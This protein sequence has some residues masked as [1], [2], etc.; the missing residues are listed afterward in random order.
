MAFTDRHE[1]Y[2]LLCK[3]MFRLDFK[4]YR[5]EHTTFYEYEGDNTLRTKLIVTDVDGMTI[6][7][8]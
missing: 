5:V 7:G 8:N 3:S 2:K 1:W 6:S 4:R